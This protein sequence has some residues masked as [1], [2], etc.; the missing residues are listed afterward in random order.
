MI[1]QKF[2]KHNINTCKFK[3]KLSHNLENLIAEIE[4][5][6]S[7]INNSN[8]VDKTRNEDCIMHV[9]Q[10]LIIDNNIFYLSSR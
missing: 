8:V 6:I 1:K 9:I 7:L 4:H 10:K 2:R 3:Q 5:A